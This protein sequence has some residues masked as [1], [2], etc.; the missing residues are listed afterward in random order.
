MGN[1]VA[2]R[3]TIIFTIGSI[4]SKINRPEKAGRDEGRGVAAG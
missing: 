1:P 2:L 4:H 3:F